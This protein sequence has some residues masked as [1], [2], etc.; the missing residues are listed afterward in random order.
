M[1]ST[2]QNGTSS[3]VHYDAAYGRQTFEPFGADGIEQNLGLQAGLGN[4]FTLAANVGLAVGNGPS[5]TSQQAEILAHL[6]TALNSPVDFSAGLGYRHEYGGTGVLLSR[7]VLGRQ[8]QS[9]E[10]YGNILIEHAF[11][12]YRDPV[13]LTTTFGYS[14]YISGGVKVGVEAV[15]QD[16]EGFWESDEAEGGA[17][18][19]AGP[20][21][22]VVFPGTNLNLVLGG[23]LIVRATHSPRTSGAYRDFNTSLGNGFV[24]R[25]T[26][27]YA[28]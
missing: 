3:F 14:R 8:F 19:Y 15:G 4:F 22:A 25:T 24:V 26:L 20:T 9:S 1:T 10:A 2:G 17:V 28:L 23:G 13:D 12:P 7:I 21:A 5:T 11:S 16:L 6:L 18:V 27:C